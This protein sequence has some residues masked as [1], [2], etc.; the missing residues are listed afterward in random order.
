MKMGRVLDMF[1]YLSKTARMTSSDIPSLPSNSSL[2]VPCSLYH[3][4]KIF[5]DLFPRDIWSQISLMVPKEFFRLCEEFQ[6]PYH[7]ALSIF[8]DVP[9]L[10]MLVRADIK[11]IYT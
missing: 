6:L 9:E 5:R 4:K 1:R 7:Y 11:K 10:V 3:E 8:V 2:P